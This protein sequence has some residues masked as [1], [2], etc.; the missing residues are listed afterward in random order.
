MFMPMLII[1]AIHESASTVRLY[2]NRQHPSRR[3]PEHAAQEDERSLEDG[4]AGS[5]PEAI[6]FDDDDGETIAST[7]WEA[8]HLYEHL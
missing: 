5:T 1:S 8:Y 4:G 2:A 6:I 3:G 7:P